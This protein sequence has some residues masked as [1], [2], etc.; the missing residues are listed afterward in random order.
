MSEYYHPESGKKV[1]IEEGYHGVMTNIVETRADGNAQSLSMKSEDVP[2][3]VE[4]LI[5]AGWL[6]RQML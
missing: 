2:R 6:P 5:N 1:K 4:G 3:F